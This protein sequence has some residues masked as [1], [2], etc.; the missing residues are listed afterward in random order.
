VGL[1]TVGVG[2]FLT[3]LPALGM[4]FLLLHCLV[5][6]QHEDFLPC[7][8]VFCFSLFGCHLLEACYF[9]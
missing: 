8:T 4:P 5:Q 1:L 9:L 3:L 2:V 6:P 7:F